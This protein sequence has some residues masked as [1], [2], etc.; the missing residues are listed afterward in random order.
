MTYG[1]VKLL[2]TIIYFFVPISERICLEDNK[3]NLIIGMPSKKSDHQA[4]LRLLNL[5]PSNFSGYYYEGKP[6][7]HC[8]LYSWFDG[9]T[10]QYGFSGSANYSQYGFF[11]KNQVNQITNDHP[12][13]I[14]DYYFELLN[15]SVPMQDVLVDDISVSS[16]QVT[17][18]S[19]A[20]GTIEWTVEDE[21]VKISF[22][23]RNGILPVKSGLNLGQ[24]LDN[25]GNQR[26]PNQAYLSIK[27]SARKEGFLPDKKFTFTMLT[28]DDEVFDCTVQQ[29]GRKAVSTTDNNSILGE[30]IRRRLGVASGSLV[31]VAD[32]ERYGRTDFTLKK[33]DN[34]TFFFDLS[35]SHIAT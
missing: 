11:E 7:V 30:Y 33:I 32:L 25:H 26:E 23:A 6:N 20:A 28:D 17:T 12:G 22:L 8:K 35:V 13:D 18:G 27:G 21:E 29:E 31:T 15:S 10:P 1:V 4:F 2:R 34:E 3:I 14:R 24:R 19:I 9:T 16:S 5:H